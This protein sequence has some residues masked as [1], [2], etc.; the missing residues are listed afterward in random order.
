MH[1]LLRSRTAGLTGLA[2]LAITTVAPVVTPM[3]ALASGSKLFITSAREHPDDTVTLP[4]HRGTSGGQTVLY[5]ITDTSDGNL[6]SSLGV[7]TSPKLANA[8]GSTAV[9]KITYN[10]DGSIDFPFTVDFAPVRVISAP[11]GFPPTVATPGAMGSINADRTGY[12][13]LIQL[14][15]GTIANAPQIANSTGQADKIVGSPDLSAMTVTYRETHGFQG[16]KSVKYVSF[17]ASNPLA[18]AL[19]NATYAPA[20]DAAPRPG[21]TAASPRAPR[22]WPSSMA[23]RASAIRSARDSTRLSPTDRIRSTCCAGT[24]ARGAIVRYGM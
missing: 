14:P 23:R 12:S 8:A 21:T 10:A 19:E 22:W 17:D 16:G 3:T 13:P 11:D 4:L 24:R 2:L 20:L 1:P 9:Q 15:N 5:V 6:S 7:N 18:A